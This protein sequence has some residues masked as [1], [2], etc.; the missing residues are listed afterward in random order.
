MFLTART[1]KKKK[2]RLVHVCTCLYSIPACTA[3]KLLL[4]YGTKKIKSNPLELHFKTSA[5][6]SRSSEGTKTAVTLPHRSESTEES[7]T[8]WCVFGSTAWLESCRITECTRKI[9]RYHRGASSCGSVPRIGKIRFV[10]DATP[11][12]IA[13]FRLNRL[14]YKTQY[15]VVGTPL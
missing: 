8:G 5:T 11:G 3:V 15:Q 7:I 6:L 2:T 12:Q 4:S 1:R 10:G 9:Q 13:Y 14:V